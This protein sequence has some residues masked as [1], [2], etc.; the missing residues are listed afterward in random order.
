MHQ[1]GRRGEEEKK[2]QKTE[3][4]SFLA[5]FSFL[6]GD[7]IILSMNT[8]SPQL[9]CL[10]HLTSASELIKHQKACPISSA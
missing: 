10:S 4:L 7:L 5:T 3:N 1:E 8:K 6:G 2:N 9:P